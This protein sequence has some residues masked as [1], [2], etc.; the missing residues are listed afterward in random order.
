[1]FKNIKTKMAGE[2]NIMIHF[3]MML[4]NYNT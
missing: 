1:M 3:K 2:A 4:M